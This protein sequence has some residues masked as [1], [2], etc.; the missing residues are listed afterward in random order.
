[1]TSAID[2]LSEEHGLLLSALAG[3]EK[4]AF[5]CMGGVALDAD[6]AHALVELIEEVGCGMH[7][8]F[9]DEL[10]FPLLESHGVTR[11]CGAIGV[12]TYEHEA[13]TEALERLNR[14]MG[15]AASGDV[16]ACRTWARQVDALGH[17]SRGH[18]AKEEGVLFPFAKC[19]LSDQ[20]NDELLA[21]M[22]AIE[23]ARFAGCRE[24]AQATLPQHLEALGVD[25]VQPL[26]HI[27]CPGDPRKC[28]RSGQHDG[29][30]EGS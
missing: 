9:E 12:L 30:R 1:M 19:N 6:R 23:E 24:R 29:C 17:I 2:Q 4:L 28:P 13:F 16:W 3:L 5:G 22:A 26:Q 27:G 8:A 18:M 14:S 25:F 7:H 15:E 10:L 20:E 21:A 11:E